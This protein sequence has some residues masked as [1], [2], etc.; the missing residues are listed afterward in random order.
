MQ[1]EIF[2][3]NDGTFSWRVIDGEKRRVSHKSFPTEYA[4]R[5]NLERTLREVGRNPVPPAD[6][7][8][9]PPDSE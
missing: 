2:E 6:T 3:R 4:A 1:T 7:E 8:T 5:R 9:N